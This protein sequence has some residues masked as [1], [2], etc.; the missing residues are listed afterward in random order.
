MG[1]VYRAT[2]T[3]LKR[4]VALKVL[5]SEWSADADRLARFQREAELLASLNHPNIAQVYGIEQAGGITALVMELVDGSTLADLI[6]AGG[7]SCDAVLPIAT[8][9]ADALEAAHEQGIIH[10]DLKPANVKVRRDGR[11]KVL[12]FGLARS[13]SA[14]A[15]PFVGAP[16]DSP[17]LTSPARLTSVGMILG[18]AAYMA[19]EQ[20]RGEDAGRP[21]DIWALGCVLFEMLSGTPT[22][23][24]ASVAEIVSNVL[25]SEPDWRQLPASTPA[26]VVRTIRRC[27]AKDPKRRLQHAGDVRLELL[28]DTP[29]VAAPPPG[30][31][32]A[33]RPPSFVARALPWTIAAAAI[34]VATAA[35]ISTRSSSTAGP[36]PVTRLD[37]DYP[38][39]VEASFVAA[40]SAGLSPDGRRLVFTG[41]ESGF[42]RLFVRD[43]DQARAQMF[44][45]T[46][47]SSQC[48]FSP[49]GT[50]VTYIA[51]DRAIRRVTLADGL[52]TVLVRGVD[53]NV[54]ASWGTDGFVTYAA[55]GELWQV[56]GAGGQARQITT[57]DRAHGELFHAWPAAVPGS[58]VVLF[59]VV[60]GG[61]RDAQRIDAV[62]TSTG[63]R[64]TVVDVGSYPMIARE[65]PIVFVR[66]GVLL[67]APIERRRMAMAGAAVKV[68]DDVAL[69]QLGAPLA[70]LSA[71]GSL[72]Y[73]SN[74]AA[75]G[76]LVW[77]SR[78]G[79]TS[80]ASE[81]RSMWDYPRLSPDGA[82]ILTTRSGD[83]WQ[84]DTGR[85]TL[86]RVTAEASAGN[87][88]GVYLPDGERIVFRTALGM[89]IGRTD[90]GAESRL[91]P[92]TS[93]NDFPHAVTNDGSTLVFTRQSP[94]AAGEVYVLSLDGDPKP[95]PL[96]TSPAY[97]GGA[98]LSPD[99]RWIAY[100]SNESGRYEVYVR[101]FPT[102]DRKAVVSTDG[103]SQA[104]WGRDGRELFYRIGTKVLSVPVTLSPD[105]SAEKPREV[106]DVEMSFGTGI[107]FAQYDVGK[108][109]RFLMIKRATEAGRLNVVLNWTSE[110]AK[111]TQSR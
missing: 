6:T 48:F 106:F 46:D 72:V 41:Q 35:L 43:L 68:L 104:M 33:Q 64:H 76:H 105:F 1:E 82:R 7:M 38:P 2:D 17:T 92:D 15:R 111:L 88:Y 51:S 30:L 80:S 9:I 79:A 54:G 47:A 44:V 63:E 78:E 58:Q 90:G 42:R 20:A 83:L 62:D 69:D 52:S 3:R 108:D 34:V 61:T 96:F 94:D 66:D 97:E 55:A 39:H 102:G 10:R 100:A 45:A 65:G 59:A 56:P 57:L 70:A 23:A 98:V 74:E 53:R 26:Q 101:R 107:T 103:G 8:Q 87:S 40:P 109:G 19:P 93:A 89:R 85:S 24:G 95:H 12:D 16:G 29:A 84:V 50:A 5:P 22:F 32:A 25:K 81:A 86:T 28:E 73:V 31:P 21:A 27:L 99:N 75:S 110:L 67:A 4:E 49:D 37:F 71:N 77:V 36:A 60:S 91:I 13:V 18:T 11:V 14:A